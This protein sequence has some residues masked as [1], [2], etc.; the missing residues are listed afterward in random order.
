LRAVGWLSRE[1][2]FSHGTVVAEVLDRIRQFGARWRESTEA[3]G[4]G[5][6]RGL[7]RCELC[8]RARMFGNFGVPAGQILYVAPEMVA[9]YVQA[10]DY[11]PPPGF[12]A[13]VMSA[14]FPGTE[15]YITLVRR[16]RRLHLR[17]EA[18]RFWRARHRWS[19][20]RQR[21][22]RVPGVR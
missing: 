10:H 16:F 7:H 1:Q 19:R 6:F 2:P 12:L 9:H 17:A 14:P 15:E 3:L 8:G 5:M 11:V 18:Q 4:W 21:P 20:K 22:V 13:A